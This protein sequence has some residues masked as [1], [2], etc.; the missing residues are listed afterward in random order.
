MKIK[1]LVVVAVLAL[2]P[3]ISI[4]N[5]LWEFVGGVVVGGLLVDGASRREPPPYYI[6]ESYRP[7]P[8]RRVLRCVDV[9]IYDSYGYGHPRRQCYEE[10]VPVY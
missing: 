6:E 8:M 1:P 7:P 5:S 9:V 10:L 3:S 2:A 4:A